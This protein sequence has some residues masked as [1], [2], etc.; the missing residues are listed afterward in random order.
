MKASTFLHIVF[1]VLCA[2]IVWSLWDRSLHFNLW[3][4][5]LSPCIFPAVL[6]VGFG[7]L[8]RR[9]VEAGRDEDG[10]DFKRFMKR[11]APAYA[12][13][14][15]AAMVALWAREGFEA[16]PYILFFGLP[17]FGGLLLVTAVIG[18]LSYYRPVIGTLFKWLWLG[19]GVCYG[20]S[21]LALVGR[22]WTAIPFLLLP[23]PGLVRDRRR[24]LGLLR[25]SPPWCLLAGALTLGWWYHDGFWQIPWRATRVPY[26]LIPWA[27]GAGVLTSAAYLFGGRTVRRVAVVCGKWLGTAA[28]VTVLLFAGAGGWNYLVRELSWREV[29]RYKVIFDAESAAGTRRETS[30]ITVERKFL[31]FGR[32]HTGAL[33]MDGS[34]PAMHLPGKG[35]LRAELQMDYKSL[36]ALPV[37]AREALKARSG[38]PVAVT[39]APMEL[40]GN[41]RPE[42][43]ITPADNIWARRMSR[44]EDNGLGIRFR[45]WIEVLKGADNLDRLFIV[46]RE[47]S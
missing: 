36:R 16:I 22:G 40:V 46:R 11:H 33:R 30:V 42:L 26:G 32:T 31:P 20:A 47:G 14:L 8:Y 19:F 10:D 29:V 34:L 17:Y 5:Y 38:Q 24:L 27:A 25:A 4:D 21:C 28:A 39:D 2:L 15:G 1:V 3:I 43:W 23:V 12:G 6:L 37:I 44:Y 41:A 18:V 7:G 9:G 35:V 13:L 45:I